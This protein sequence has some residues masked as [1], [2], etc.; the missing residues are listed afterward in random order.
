VYQR[1]AVIQYRVYSDIVFSLTEK[2]LLVFG[3]LSDK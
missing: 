3:E 2:S 1:K